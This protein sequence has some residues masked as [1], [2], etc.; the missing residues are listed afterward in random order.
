ICGDK[1]WRALPPRWLGVSELEKAL[2][3]ISAVVERICNETSHA[4]IVLEEGGSEIAK[5]VIQNK[6]ALDMLLVS[7]GGECT[8]IN[9]ICCVFIDQSGRISTDLN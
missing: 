9:T 2:V 6:V 3:S 1:T 5:I 8:V 4:I 7:Q